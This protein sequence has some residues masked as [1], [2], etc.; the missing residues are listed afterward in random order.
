MKKTWLV[1]ALILALLPVGVVSSAQATPKTGGTLR[2]A[3][4]TTPPSLDPMANT[5]FGFKTVGLHI[6]ESLVTFDENF[7]VSPQIAERW[8]ISKDGKV[9]TF[10]LRKGLKFHNG[11]DV[12]ATDVKASIERFKAGAA[13]RQELDIVSNIE[14]VN[15]TT[16]R[17]TLTTES[18]AFL[19]ALANPMCQLAIIPAEFKD[20]PINQLQPIGTGPF[21]FVEWIPDR[22]IKLVKYDGYKP[23]DTPAS[24]FAGK[25]AALVDELL[26]IPVPE[27]GARVA[28]LERGEY[29]FIEDVPATS[30]P[31]LEKRNDLVID[32]LAPYTYVTLYFNFTRQFSDLRMRKAVQLALNMDEI[33]LVAGEGAG[34]VDPGFYFLEQFWHSDA[35]KESYNQHDVARAK[36][37]L[38]EAGYNGEQIILVTNTDYA[39]MYKAAL[40]VLQQLKAIGMNIKLE[41]YDWPGALAVRADLKKWDLFFSSHSTRFDPTAN[42]FYYYKSTTFFGY[43][44]PEM[45]AILNEAKR[46]SDPTARRALYE[47]AQQK[48]Y[49]E[50]AML[51]LFDL[52]MYEGLRSHVKDF[53]FWVMPYFWNVWLDK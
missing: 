40:V 7:K 10:Y 3:M 41:V 11:K 47:K 42:D 25:R 44:N 16:I 36:A 37:L 51:K 52:N 50:A 8:E 15:A 53:K 6:F 14:V 19:A 9:Y 26:F 34:R 22:H 24:G 12:T 49:D 46:L 45:E 1:L 18:G 30:V 2:V 33:A 28:G 5:H 21:K 35:G 31:R 17:L 32:Q 20:V 27:P 29:D 38:K 13:R 23:L 39:Y 48:V 4:S 43:D